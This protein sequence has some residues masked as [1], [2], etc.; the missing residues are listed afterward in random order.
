MGEYLMS[1]P[2]FTEDMKLVKVHFPKWTLSECMIMHHILKEKGYV[3]NCV[4]RIGC[5]GKY[6]DAWEVER[7]DV[8]RLIE[9][10]FRQRITVEVQAEGHGKASINFVYDYAAETILSACKRFWKN[11]REDCL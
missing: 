7:A 6:H 9:Q 11:N 4:S 2:Y 5:D 3:M 10:L 1:E 8:P